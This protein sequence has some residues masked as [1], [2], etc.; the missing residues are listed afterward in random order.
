[1]VDK[2]GSDLLENE[3]LTR[4]RNSVAYVDERRLLARL[5]IVGTD[6]SVGVLHS[7]IASSADR[8]VRVSAAAALR[9]IGTRAA[10]DALADSLRLS[11]GTVV[12]FVARALGSINARSAVPALIACLG[13]ADTPASARTAV[14]WA[15][16]RLPDSAAIGVLGKTLSSPRAGPRKVAAYALAKIDSPDAR[17]QLE[18]A[19][20]VPSW[21]GGRFARRALQQTIERSS[22]SGR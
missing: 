8:R 13:S 11:D 10:V 1:V 3:V 9:A 16:F 5:E 18:A 15:L 17:A 22:R 21:W 19:R 2:S 20:R 4:L 12:A 7:L 14:A 6:A